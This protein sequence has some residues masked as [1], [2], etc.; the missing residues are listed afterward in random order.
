[1]PTVSGTFPA[2]G[3]VLIEWARRRQGLVVAA[4]NPLG[5]ETIGD[6]A[7]KGARVVA[8]QPEAGSYLLLAHLLEQAGLAMED[9]T[10]VEGTARSETDLG[11]AVLEG[12]ADAGLAV[13]AA[14]RTLKLDFLP[15]AEERYDLL[16]RRRD[17]FEAPM[18]ALLA[19]AR[20]P[21]MAERA[22]QMGGYDLAATG[23]VRF[24]GP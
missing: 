14:A 1:M 22:A 20:T 4:G 16:M 21:A 19:F 6:L 11:L 23:T 2:L 3:A 24:N 10:F 13:E 9:L 5:L 18:Q 17:Y 12:R 8:R 7:A 15:L